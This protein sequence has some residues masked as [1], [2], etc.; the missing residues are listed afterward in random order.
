MEAPSSPFKT[1]ATYGLIF[2]GIVALYYLFNFLY[3]S[4]DIYTVELLNKQTDATAVD[5][6]RLPAIP[7][8]Q[9]GGE[10]SV[11]VWVY[12]TSF[13]AAAGAT[14]A[15]A[16][17]GRRHIFE[18]AGTTFSTLLI[19]LGA[20]Q[21]SLVTIVETSETPSEQKLKKSGTTG[22]VTK[23]LET[24]V[25][26]GNPGTCDAP[27]INLQRWV[28]I[29]VV[30]NNR[31]CDVYLDGKLTRSCVL[32]NYFKVETG[33]G[34]KVSPVIAGHGGFNGYV[35][36]TSVSNYALNPEEIYR[37]YS[38]GPTG[39]SWN[40]LTAAKNFFGGVFQ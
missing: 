6:T 23:A 12:I 28:L 21:S 8:P 33:S 2:L 25:E 26:S 15:N 10:Y 31:T 39:S 35:Q 30:L 1:V 13:R 40:P 4:S 32:P 9:A 22:T 24:L 36:L 38:A 20:D 7:Q 14:G 27:E 17:N 19:A 11:N 3:G 16:T 29:T 5:S 34:M 18:L 37:I